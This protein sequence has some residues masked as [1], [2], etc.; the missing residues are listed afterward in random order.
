MD[1]V[2]HTSTSGGEATTTCSVPLDYYKGYAFD[3]VFLTF[4]IACTALVVYRIARPK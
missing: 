1:S 3:I 2:C 4:M